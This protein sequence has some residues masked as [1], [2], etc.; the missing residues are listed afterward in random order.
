VAIPFAVSTGLAAAYTIGLWAVMIVAPLTITALKRH[1]LLFAAGWVTVGVVW[2]IAS[3]RL[4]RPESWWAR[5]FYGPDKLARAQ[6]RYG[7]SPG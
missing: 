5:R 3:L 2:W 4:A 6:K 1:W 7:L